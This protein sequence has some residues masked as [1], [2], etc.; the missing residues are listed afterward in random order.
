MY[1]QFGHQWRRGWC[2]EASS[3]KRGLRPYV[4][5][6]SLLARKM[7]ILLATT[8]MACRRCVGS[9]DDDMSTGEVGV[10]VLVARLSCLRAVRD[11]PAAPLDLGLMAARLSD[12]TS[13]SAACARTSRAV[14][15]LSPSVG[16]KMRMRRQCCWRGRVLARLH[17]CKGA[18]AALLLA[19]TV[20]LPPTAWPP[21]PTCFAPPPPL[22]CDGRRPDAPE[23][24][25]AAHAAVGW[26]ALSASVGSSGDGPLSARSALLRAA[27][28]RDPTPS[29][30][31]G[32]VHRR[33]G[34][35]CGGRCT[36]RLSPRALRGR[37]VHSHPAPA[38]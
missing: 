28:R 9:G 38:A 13:R 12:A 33:H 15:A 17:A 32:R 5:S 37:P 30:P 6:A 22:G 31:R 29:H 14:A 36:R 11:V 19:R 20:R 27:T 1:M 34:R 24:A 18:H 2:A 25:R 7:E 23:V 21:G 10:T 8:H 35:R 4:T 3:C 16:D 26:G